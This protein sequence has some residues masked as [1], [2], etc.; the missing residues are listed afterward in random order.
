[1]ARSLSCC[2]IGDIRQKDEPPEIRADSG[3]EG[4]NLALDGLIAHSLP[5]QGVNPAL[6]FGTQSFLGSS[7]HLSRHL[8]CQF[9]NKGPLASE[10]KTDDL[11]AFP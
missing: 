3:L 9:R 2:T 11:C 5:V 1:M 8:L 10:R 7:W 6:Q 4:A